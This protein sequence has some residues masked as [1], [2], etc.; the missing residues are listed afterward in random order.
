MGG[1]WGIGLCTGMPLVEILET[2]RRRFAEHHEERRISKYVEVVL[3]V[4]GC[5]IYRELLWSGG[6]RA[7]SCQC[8]TGSRQMVLVMV[9]I[10]KVKS[11]ALEPAPTKLKATGQ[12]L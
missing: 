3:Y 10:K 7:E 4:Y 5:C 12:K 8:G 6:R 9:Y 11:W 2:W 1:G